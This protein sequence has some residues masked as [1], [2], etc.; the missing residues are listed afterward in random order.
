MG[1]QSIQFFSLAKELC[2]SEYRFLEKPLGNSSYAQML[3]CSLKV[4]FLHLHSA[5]LHI[6]HSYCKLDA[7]MAEM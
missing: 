7:D 6:A 2:S 5:H 1:K 4:A 3:K